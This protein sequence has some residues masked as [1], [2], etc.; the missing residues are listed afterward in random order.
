MFN[1]KKSLMLSDKGYAN[2]KKAIA[3]C[4]LTNLA[5]FLPFVVTVL[6]FGELL[7]PL[8]GEPM[9]WT[10]MWL[11]FGFGIVAAVL[12]FLASKNDY[13]KTYLA[14]YLESE[15][16]RTR[17]AEHIR[18]L[19]MS[20]FNEKNL[21]ELSTNIIGDCTDQELVL[22]HIVPQ[23]IANGISI[24]VIC[25]LLVLFDWRM[26]LAVFC[27]V[28]VAFLV[29]TLSRKMQT[30]AGE[31]TVETKL[32][33]YDQMQEYLEGIKIIKSCGLE[34]E[35]FSAL[36]DALSRLAKIAIKLELIYG[37]FIAGGQMILQAG[38]GLT[39]FVG[40]YLLTAGKIELIPLMIFLLIVVRVYGPVITLL[41]LL[42]ELLFLHLST[43]RMR[44]LFSTPAMA[45]DAAKEIRDYG[46]NFE[47]VSFSYNKSSN[48][49]E[50]V[51][52]D[53]SISIPAN[54]VTA[55]VGPSGGGKSTVLKLMARFWDVDKGAVKIGGVDVKT[56]DPEHLMNYMS[57]VF[58]DVVL[59]NDTVYNNIRIGNLNASE[60]QVLAAAK[61]AGCDEFVS[62][63]PDGY[64]TVL[65]ESG[66]TLSGGE[67]QRI[68]IARALLKNAPV[69]LLDE[70]TAFLD[71]ENEVFVQ[72]AISRLIEG[73]TVIVIAHRLRTVAGAGKIIV[74]DNGKALEEG[75][76]EELI[77]KKGLYAKLYTIQQES[78]GWSV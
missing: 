56:L 23:L 51:I 68:S 5:L 46:I 43:R 62:A 13:R 50:T 55:L 40:T 72:Q 36:R 42:P 3:A 71:P 52:K 18:K 53:L 66:S 61:A 16:T 74:L 64:Q 57:F 65:G 24:T 63:L 60:E 41:T 7:K 30:S 32:A 25:L 49:E 2:L 78:L 10:K 6:I 26:A 37:I 1:L 67:R 17:V 27:T 39:V 33:A 34:G 75:T 20:F 70:A 35:K 31:K 19:P 8:T 47:N 44:T 29:I 28:P 54:S 73:K 45:G 11:Y 22:S 15:V 77:S 69:I 9:S 38:I 21:S 58:Q 59:F 14:S 4:T 76:H 48:P 12:V